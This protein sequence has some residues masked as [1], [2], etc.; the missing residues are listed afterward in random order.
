MSSTTAGGGVGAGGGGGANAP[1]ASHARRSPFGGVGAFGLTAVQFEHDGVGSGT[2][3]AASVGVPKTR[4]RRIDYERDRVSSAPPRVDYA[5]LGARPETSFWRSGAQS[6]LRSP[7][8]ESGGGTRV[9]PRTS[10]QQGGTH[11]S[12]TARFLADRERVRSATGSSRDRVTARRSRVAG[13]RPRTSPSLVRGGAGLPR[14]GSRTLAIPLHGSGGGGA[15]EA[16]GYAVYGGPSRGGAH[17]SNSTG[18]TVATA[19]ATRGGHEH[20]AWRRRHSGPLESAWDSASND[21]GPPS[22]GA[23]L[24]ADSG[25]AESLHQSKGAHGRS[26]RSTASAGKLAQLR[27][28]RHA[29][30][31][32][33]YQDSLP[34]EV[35]REELRDA[36][37]TQNALASRLA[38][39]ALR[40]RKLAARDA[41]KSALMFLRAQRLPRHASALGEGAVSAEEAAQARADAAERA[42]QLRV[43]LR[44][45]QDEAT[46]AKAGMESA[47]AEAKAGGAARR[48][49]AAKAAAAA[50]AQ[51]EAAHAAVEATAAQKE[52]ASLRR[53]LEA[54]K[55]STALLKRTQATLLQK[56]HGDDEAA[57]AAQTA[58]L[59]EMEG[60]LEKQKLAAEAQH[61]ADARMI[62]QE[63]ARAAAQAAAQL[64]AAKR[65][66]A[67]HEAH[68]VEQVA[69]AAREQGAAATAAMLANEQS[70]A[71]SVATAAAVAQGS[72]AA[73]AEAA[74]AR[75]VA[76]DAASIAAAA[77]QGT[78]GARAA[79]AET[80]MD[81]QLLKVRE[82]ELQAEVDKRRKE[83]VILRARTAWVG[84]AKENR[85]KALRAELESERLHSRKLVSLQREI[86]NLAK[87]QGEAVNQLGTS[88][89]RAKQREARYK[90]KVEQLRKR[91][92]NEQDEA[93]MQVRQ[94]SVC[95]VRSSRPFRACARYAHGHCPSPAL[96][97]VR[98]RAP[99]RVPSATTERHESCHRKGSA[100]SHIGA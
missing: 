92:W 83:N 23:A 31:T 91:Q 46:W 27:R 55:R 70:A 29:Q 58:K 19:A 69:L 90:Q 12:A 56:A 20:G 22:P 51:A 57:L 65:Q 97:L 100:R 62:E 63:A 25:A 74:A 76:S 45:A 75:K 95:S 93:Q 13:P 8:A 99:P 21:S 54:E 30:Q 61:A 84:F 71:T 43:Q 87:E 49:A 2:F 48:E 10:A 80:R 67:E 41:H 34:P 17:N 40:A 24:S 77:E 16:G 39:E 66:A 5:A 89:T 64:E 68:A 18:G 88:L 82:S 28:A 7:E 35:L 78:K 37:A 50:R 15:G 36:Q 1:L 73:A 33:K 72:A 98:V 4:P 44:K 26:Q 96:P 79:L 11:G 52:A 47:A 32:R 3:D 94:R 6:G 60:E 59:H 85:M 9:R 42:M 81:L 53:E 86:G 38:V 14:P